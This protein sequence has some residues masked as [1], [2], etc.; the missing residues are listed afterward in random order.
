MLKKVYS[1]SAGTGKTH[2]IVSEAFEFIKNDFEKLKKI[3]FIT[4]SNAGAEEIR[5]RIYEKLKDKLKDPSRV[6]FLSDKIRVYTIHSF[7][8]ELCRIFRYELNFSYDMRF[9]I[10]EDVTIWDETTEEFF[11]T[12]WGYSKL[13]ALFEE[14]EKDIFDAFYYLSDKNAIKGFIKKYGFALFF[15]LDSGLLKPRLRK[16]I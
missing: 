12:R 7:C 4:F 13:G 1:A 15:L 8:R 16:K 2:T 10:S 5:E 3:V 11:E 9:P 6:F 14:K